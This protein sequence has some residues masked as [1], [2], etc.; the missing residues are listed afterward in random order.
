MKLLRKIELHNTTD[1]YKKWLGEEYLFPDGSKMVICRW[2]RIEKEKEEL[3]F[4]EFPDSA[5]DF[6]DKKVAE[7]LRKNYE[8]AG[9]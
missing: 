5:P 6:F 1:G 9:D 4:K 2:G 3:Q 7:K 8:L